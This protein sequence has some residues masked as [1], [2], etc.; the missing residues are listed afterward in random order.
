LHAYEDGPVVEGR[1]VEEAGYERAGE[2]GVVAVLVCD[3]REEVSAGEEGGRGA[4]EV[5]FGGG[6]GDGDL[7]FGH[8]VWLL[9]V[10]KGE[11]VCEAAG[12]GL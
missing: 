5:D 8:C 9:V 12:A 1:A 2:E 6:V 10:V 7:V 3:W 4:G 11:L